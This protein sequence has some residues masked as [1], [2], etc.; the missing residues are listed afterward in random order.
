MR[1]VKIF[2]RA[3][4]PH[5][6][7][8]KFKDQSFNKAI[9]YIDQNLHDRIFIETVAKSVGVGRTSL[10]ACSNGISAQ[11]SINTSLD[12]ALKKRVIS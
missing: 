9:T 12:A 6:A 3:S 2:D 7:S 10:L 8:R 4:L 11:L 5:A 1:A